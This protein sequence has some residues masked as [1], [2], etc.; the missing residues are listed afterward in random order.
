MPHEHSDV[1]A[2]GGD[3]IAPTR[4]NDLFQLIEA[5][6][7]R[8]TR[9]SGSHHI[10]SGRAT[11]GLR[12]S[13]PVSVHGG[14]VDHVVAHDVAKRLAQRGRHSA[15]RQNRH[16]LPGASPGAPRQKERRSEDGSP[17]R[18]EEYVVEQH[19][20]KH[21]TAMEPVTLCTAE[22]TEEHR[23]EQVAQDQEQL[24]K[25]ALQHA[26]A[27]VGEVSCSLVS[28]GDEENNPSALDSA[29]ALLDTLLVRERKGGAW[30][31]LCGQ[32]A[33]SLTNETIDVI[34]AI[35]FLRVFVLQERGLWECRATE[36]SNLGSFGKAQQQAD[37]QQAFA[38]LAA[39]WAACGAL[40]VAGER[41]AAAEEMQRQLRR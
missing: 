33:F 22:T 38:E 26:W 29:L 32:Q 23:R 4:S 2:G 34:E 39:Y 37:V 12:V 40:T 10:C 15:D 14:K 16:R 35:V 11:G 9:I 28:S 31:L 41:R 6:G 27:V 5:Y 20:N 1:A 13:F 17:A 21:K 3:I 8:V 24:L 36:G 7:Y 18:E 25:Q 30:K 19:S